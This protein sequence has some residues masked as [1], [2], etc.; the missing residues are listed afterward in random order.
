MRNSIGR[1]AAPAALALMFVFPS[2]SHASTAS[3]EACRKEGD[4]KIKFCGQLSTK[5]AQFCL[6]AAMKQE[7]DCYKK[8]DGKRPVSSTGPSGKPGGAGVLDTGGSGKP[9]NA[10]NNTSPGGGVIANPASPPKGVGNNAPVGGGVFHQPSTTGS[11]GSG[12]ILKST[13]G[14]GSTF[15]SGGNKR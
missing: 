1:F 4:A 9:A 3:S 12:T 14:S 13:A 10:G 5:S 11:G 15:R 8:G 7:A 2:I 6:D